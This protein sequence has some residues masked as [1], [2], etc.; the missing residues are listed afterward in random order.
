MGAAGKKEMHSAI[1]QDSHRAIRFRLHSE[2]TPWQ[3]YTQRGRAEQS[4]RL[5][6]HPSIAIPFLEVGLGV[7]AGGGVRVGFFFGVI[8]RGDVVTGYR[9]GRYRIAVVRITFDKRVIYKCCRTFQPV[10]GR[11]RRHPSDSQ[12]RVDRLAA[13]R[14]SVKWNYG[15]LWPILFP[16]K[17]ESLPLMRPSTVTSARKFAEVAF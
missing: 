10:G 5:L 3:G 6:P 4:R 7:A 1:R 11:R 14:N 13:C 12:G 16:T 15:S 17:E 9:V 8:L 2:Q